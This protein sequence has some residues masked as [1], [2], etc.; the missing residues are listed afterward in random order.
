MRGIQ[1]KEND[2][3]GELAAETLIPQWGVE[4]QPDFRGW[5]AV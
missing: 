5:G 4:M 2:L 1:K 3:S